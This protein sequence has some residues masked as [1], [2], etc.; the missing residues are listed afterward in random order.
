MAPLLPHMAF[1]VERELQKIKIREQRGAD[2]HPGAIL[3]RIDADG[4]DLGLAMAK[5]EGTLTR[6]VDDAVFAENA[7]HMHPPLFQIPGTEDRS[8][9]EQVRAAEHHAAA[10][11]CFSCGRRDTH[12]RP[13]RATS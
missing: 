2:Y 13:P 1:A 12:G 4:A 3:Q 7:A 9:H 6:K 11:R 5:I 8:A 10:W